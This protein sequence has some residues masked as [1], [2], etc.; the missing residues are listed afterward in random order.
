M[1]D[2]EIGIYKDKFYKAI[3]FKPQKEGDIACN[4]CAFELGKCRSAIIAL[5]QCYIVEDG[6]EIRNVYYKEVSES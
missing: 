1:E 2:N 6:I 3:E 5:G 4:H